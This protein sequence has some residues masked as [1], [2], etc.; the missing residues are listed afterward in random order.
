[1][2]TVFPPTT[3]FI[4]A[5]NICNHEL[6]E[7]QHPNCQILAKKRE[8]PE[9]FKKKLQPMNRKTFWM[10]KNLSNEDKIVF[11]FREVLKI[12]V[13]GRLSFPINYQPPVI[14]YLHYLT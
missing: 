12:C 2:F 6:S 5:A 1:M 7:Q 9:A 8:K 3:N 13:I 14:W 11:L 4:K 10:P